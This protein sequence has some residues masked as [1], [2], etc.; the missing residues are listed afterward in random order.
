M[1]LFLG[2]FLDNQFL[3]N[4]PF[5]EIK[6]I[7]GDDIKKIKIENTH[8]TWLFLGN[9][10]SDRLNN[11]IEIIELHKE[12]FHGVTFSSRSLEYWPPRKSSR[13]IILAGI[14]NKNPDLVRLVAPIQNHICNPSFREDFL[15]HVTVA[16]FKQDRTVN[17]KITLPGVTYFNWEINE[18][19]LI[20]STL[21]SNGSVYEK[22]RIWN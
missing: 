1:R 11:L 12:I 9:V 10:E 8:I 20:K 6:E 15:P 3:K 4:I 13:L 21:T 2:T 16:R 17:K 22:I 18:I 19:A 7:F 5:E 14:L